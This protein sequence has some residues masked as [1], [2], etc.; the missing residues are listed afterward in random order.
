MAARGDEGGP[1]ARGLA[2]GGGAQHRAAQVVRP[3]PGEV[4]RLSHALLPR[5]RRAAGS[6]GDASGTMSARQSLAGLRRQDHRPPTG[7]R[8]AARSHE[9]LEEGYTTLKE[10]KRAVQVKRGESPSELDG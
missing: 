10:R 7:R 8:N 4:R 9:G 1:A 2:E 6:G 3:R 5:S